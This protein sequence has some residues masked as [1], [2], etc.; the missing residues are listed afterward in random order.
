MSSS[1]GAVSGVSAGSSA[2]LVQGMDSLTTA[3]SS[4]IIPDQEYL[5][6]GSILDPHV[7][8]I[9]QLLE[10]GKPYF[11]SQGAPGGSGTMSIIIDENSDTEYFPQINLKIKFEELIIFQYWH[12]EEIISLI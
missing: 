10:L 3:M 12:W 8:V 6:Q 5:L 4:N 1:S 11:N 9:I 7:E 2:P